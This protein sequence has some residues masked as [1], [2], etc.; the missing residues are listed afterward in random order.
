M[1]YVWFVAEDAW[2]V[3]E[4]VLLFGKNIGLEGKDVKSVEEGVG[5]DENVMLLARM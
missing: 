3:P 1:E 4:N 2:K 5:L